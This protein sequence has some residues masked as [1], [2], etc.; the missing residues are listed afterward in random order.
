MVDQN[1]LD[2]INI[3][4]KNFLHTINIDEPLDISLVGITQNM[5]ARITQEMPILKKETDKNKVSESITQ[6]SRTTSIRYTTS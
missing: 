3:G 5:L 6:I 2:A 1:L 4:E